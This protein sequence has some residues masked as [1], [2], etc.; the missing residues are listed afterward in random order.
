MAELVAIKGSKEGLRVQLDEAAEWP[1][2][3]DSLRRQLAHSGS[4]F[5]GA[6]LTVDVGERPLNDAQLADMLTLLQQHGLRPQALAAT[7]RES[8]NAA[9][10]VGITAR[11][12]A[13][14]APAPAAQGS[15]DTALLVRR[16]VRSGQ[17]VRH[18]GHITVLGDV[19]AGAEII[20]GGS[21][22]VWGRLRGV[23]HAGALGDRA[24][25]ICALELRPT[26]LRIADLIAHG[27]RSAAGRTPEVACV[28]QER[29]SVESWEAYRR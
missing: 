22:V 9:R 12:P 16:T 27:D 2:V 5:N 7:T 15:E 1:Q 14:R 3:L 20:A 6:Q 25:L 18:T 23:V 10:A 17:V 19:N 11:P 26:Q 29:I 8:R 24:A 4:F 21:V 13:A 28:E